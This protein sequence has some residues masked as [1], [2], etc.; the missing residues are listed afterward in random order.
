MWTAV[1]VVRE[2]FYLM[3][4]GPSNKKHAIS[5]TA[6]VLYLFVQTSSVSYTQFLGNFGCGIRIKLLK[7]GFKSVLQEKPTRYV[8]R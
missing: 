6:S 7:S 2:L 8:G 1:S 5:A 4:C 3:E